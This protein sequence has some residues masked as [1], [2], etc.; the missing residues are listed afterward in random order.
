[1]T[2]L[3]AAASV[4]CGSDDAPDAGTVPERLR[5]VIVDVEASGITEVES[6][7][8]RSGGRTYEIDVTKETDLA[9]PP[10]HLSEHR[11]S[12][13]PVV[14]ELEEADG[15]LVATSVDDG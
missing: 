5:G 3:V 1:M 2:I 11:A 10:A 15:G 4:A 13:E 6:F 7:T 14:V 8:L 9:F 12:G